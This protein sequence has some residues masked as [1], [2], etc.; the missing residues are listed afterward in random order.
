[1][2]LLFVPQGDEDQH[3]DGHEIRQHV[4]EVRVPPAQAGDDE[5]HPEQQAEQVG[6]P[7]GV[8]CPPGGEDHQR[9]GQPA[10]GLDGAVVGPGALDVVHGVV[11]AAE[12]GDTGAHA[13]GQVLVAGDVDARRIRRGGILADRPQIQTHPG[14]VEEQLEHHGQHDGQ[15]HHEAIVQ[16][17]PAHY[18]EVRDGVDGGPVH[19]AGGGHGDLAHAAGHGVQG[20]AEEVGHAA[21]EDGQRQAGD[22]LV[23]PEGDGQETVQQTAQGGGGE[24]RQ[25]GDHQ[26]HEAGGIGVVELIEEGGRQSRDAAQIHDPGDAQVQ[27]AG[28]LCQDLAHGAEQDDG[29]ELDGRLNQLNNLVDAHLAP[30]FPPRRMMR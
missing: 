1:M 10:Q 8:D 24:R 7:D 5:V 17:Q 16:Q 9:H 25:Q 22:V 23:G 18:A 28:F 15:I 21:A 14:P 12:T 27:V 2:V 19:G 29:A 20:A 30:S 6:A 11:Q 26:T 13:G 4:E 3:R